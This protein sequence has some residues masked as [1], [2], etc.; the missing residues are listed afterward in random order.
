MI[1]SG[2]NEKLIHAL[3]PKCA[4][5]PDPGSLAPRTASEG[6]PYASVRPASTKVRFTTKGTSVLGPRI[7]RTAS[8]K[9]NRPLR[10]A[11]RRTSNHRPPSGGHR[12]TLPAGVCLPHAATEVANGRVTYV[13]PKCRAM[14]PIHCQSFGGGG[15]RTDNRLSRANGIRP[16]RP[17]PR[18][19][20][21]RLRLAPPRRTASATR[22]GSAAAP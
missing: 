12:D 2:F 7:P 1:A 8:R 10:E 6:E 21:E 20:A 15:N 22:T 17:F 18:V 9:A 3:R 11:P 13:N 14:A 19:W 5:T 4:R 16:L